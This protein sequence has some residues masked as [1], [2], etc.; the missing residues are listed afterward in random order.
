MPTW[1]A[2]GFRYDETFRQ[3]LPATDEDGRSHAGVY[4]AGDGAAI[5]G[6]KAAELSG[7]LAALAALSDFGRDISQIAVPRFATPSHAP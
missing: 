2:A 5:G 6:A 4:L 1:P 3:W 7:R